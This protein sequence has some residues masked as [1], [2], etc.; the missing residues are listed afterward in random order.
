MPHCS[1]FFDGTCPN[2]FGKNLSGHAGSQMSDRC[3]LGYLFLYLFSAMQSFRFK[4]MR[5]SR[6]IRR[7]L[8]IRSVTG[9]IVISSQT[10]ISEA[11]HSEKCRTK[12][13]ADHRE[14]SKHVSQNRRNDNET[15]YKNEGSPIP[16]PRRYGINENVF[17]E[18]ISKPEEHCTAWK[19][20][21]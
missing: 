6:R 17:T 19:R 5:L 15:T 12:E 7:N 11:H 16:L 9:R 13:T 21:I 8:K 20:D 3:P 1:I 10:E 14:I 18:A 2:L 4:G